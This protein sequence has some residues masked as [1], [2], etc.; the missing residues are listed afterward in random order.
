MRSVISA[1][2]IFSLLAPSAAFAF[3]FG[4]Q[5]SQIVPCYNQAIYSSV[6]PPRGGPYIWT[7]STKTYEFGAPSFAGQWLL[8][9]AGAPYYCLVSIVPVIV[10]SGIAITM[11]GS[12]GGGS[13]S[14]LLASGVSQGGRQPSINELVTPKPFNPTE[15]LPP[16]T[17]PDTPTTIGHVVISEVFFNVDAAHGSNPGDQ[18]VELYNGGTVTVDF[19]G[20]A[21]QSGSEFSAIPNGTTLPPSRM[22]LIIASAS[23]AQ[24]WSVPAGVG[25]VS[26]NAL[27][28]G[29]LHV[30]GGE[31]SLKNKDGNVADAVSW[32]DNT[33]AFNPSVPTVPS[34]YSIA[35]SGLAQDTNSSGDWKALS[36]PTPG[37]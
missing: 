25:I 13:Y 4:G 33:Q 10:W 35:R 34:G 32:G 5:I 1:A 6:G 28:A 26:I 27:I 9:L 19:S 18:W 36:V 29:G 12:S 31:L 8:G 3:P 16:I 20:W 7:P 24:R 17:P 37:R 15:P 11:M 21:L 30:A 2:V 14:N 23:T 22:M